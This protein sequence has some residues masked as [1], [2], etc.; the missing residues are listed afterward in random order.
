MEENDHN[1][2]IG[3]EIILGGLVFLGVDVISLIID[4]TGIGMAVAPV[5]QSGS[6][7]ALSLWS[8]TKGGKNTFSFSRQLV[9]H[10]SGIIPLIPTTVFIFALDVYLHNHPT[11]AI[12]QVSKLSIKKTP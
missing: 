2:F 5:L 1:P 12:S 3:A 7:V 8:Q 6:V 10:A 4:L 9:K 11:S